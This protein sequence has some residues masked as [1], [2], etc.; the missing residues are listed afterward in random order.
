ME[1]VWPSLRDARDHLMIHMSPI[2]F[3]IP[4]IGGSPCDSRRCPCPSPYLSS[5]GGAYRIGGIPRVV[6]SA[7]QKVE[8]TDHHCHFRHKYAA[9]WR[10]AHTSKTYRRLEVIGDAAGKEIAPSRIGFRHLVVHCGSTGPYAPLF[11]R[12]AIQEKEALMW[13]TEHQKKF[14]RQMEESPKKACCQSIHTYTNYA[15]TIAICKS[16]W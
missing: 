16:I 12:E 8:I 4:L 3:K 13:P 14:R 7:S 2:A 9:S 11:S 10:T 15:N 6:P 1:S 5:Y